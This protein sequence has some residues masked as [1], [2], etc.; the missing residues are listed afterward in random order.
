MAA[1]ATGT[2]VAATVATPAA[3]AAGHSHVQAAEGTAVSDHD[4][5]S[6]GAA[7][8]PVACYAAAAP[9]ATVATGDSG[10]Y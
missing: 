1:A 3:I 6:A 2:A 8:A 7:A 10:K 4:A 5:P 9:C